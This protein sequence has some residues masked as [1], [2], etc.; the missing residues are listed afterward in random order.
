MTIHKINFYLNALKEAPEHQ[1][2]F[3]YIDRL[4]QMQQA[5]MEIIPPQLAEPCSVGRFSDGKLTI[6]VGNGAVA[7]K[8]KQVLP[9]LLLKFQKRGYVE[10]TAIQITVQAN[11]Y[12]Y[13]A[14]DSS[15][16]RPEMGQAGTESLRK[17]A[18]SLPVSPL[19]IA[20]KSMLK[21]RAKPLKKS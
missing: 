7:A 9:S 4:T 3:T 20:V 14:D 21:K 5:F 6:L 8:L 1:E 15:R 18:T 17:F 16:E 13:S 2:L 10:V 11:Y 19:K 12:T